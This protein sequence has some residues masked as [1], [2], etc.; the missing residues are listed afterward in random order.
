MSEVLRAICDKRSNFNKVAFYSCSLTGAYTS[1]GTLPTFVRRQASIT[2]K[3]DTYFLAMG[4]AQYIM[5]TTPPL[6]VRYGL[7]PTVPTTFA[8]QRAATAESYS[9]AP[10]IRINQ[11]YAL[12]QWLTWEEYVLFRPAELINVFEDVLASIPPAAPASNQTVTVTLMGIE[13][14]FPSTDNGGFPNG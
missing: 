10:Q 7:D 9:I 14:R 4:A 13:Y 11:N 2:C 5:V 8:I 12:N 3:A 1:A 6:V